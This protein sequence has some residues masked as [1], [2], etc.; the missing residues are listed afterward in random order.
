MMYERWEAT[1]K[2]CEQAFIKARCNSQGRPT[3]LTDDGFRKKREEL[4]DRDH[5]GFCGIDE[6]SVVILLCHQL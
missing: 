3:M 4:L 6:W 1:I 2:M 5:D